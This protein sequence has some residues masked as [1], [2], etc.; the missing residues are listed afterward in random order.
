MEANKMKI[1]TL[2]MVY[3]YVWL[4]DENANIFLNL[5][6]LLIIKMIEIMFKPC[7]WPFTNKVGENICK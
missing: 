1:L 6:E 3:K 5:K 7:G 4:I 2:N